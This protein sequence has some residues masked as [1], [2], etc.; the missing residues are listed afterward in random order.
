MDGYV[1]LPFEYGDRSSVECDSLAAPPVLSQRYPGVDYFDECRRMWL[2]LQLVLRQKTALE[3]QKFALEARLRGSEKPAPSVN[4][5]AHPHAA[6]APPA[7]A[8]PS[9]TPSSTP[10]VRPSNKRTLE[11]SD[12]GIS[13][14]SSNSSDSSEDDDGIVADS[15]VD[16][17]DAQRKKRRRRTYAELSRTYMCPVASCS[18]CYASEG[19]LNQHLKIKHGGGTIRSRTLGVSSAIHTPPASPPGTVVAAGAHAA[20]MRVA[21]SRFPYHPSLA[22]MDASAFAGDHAGLD[23]PVDL[24]LNGGLHESEPLLAALGETFAVACDAGVPAVPD[25]FGGRLGGSCKASVVTENPSDELARMYASVMGAGGDAFHPAPNLAA[26]RAALAPV[27]HQR[28]QQQQRELQSFVATNSVAAAHRLPLRGMPPMAPILPKPHPAD[29]ALA[30]RESSGLGSAVL[31]E[32]LAMV[33]AGGN[34]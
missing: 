32:S 18:R 11:H 10:V 2:E 16:G 8:A 21:P 27:T 15:S 6:P 17:T 20:Q 3:E 12:S 34:L 23:V 33:L 13:A 4:T 22:M 1:T 26:S 29:H 25:P 14:T 28:M 9:S 24:D 7:T 31:H 19:S 30:M 5:V